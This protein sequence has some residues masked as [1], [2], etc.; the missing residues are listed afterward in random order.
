MGNKYKS[1]FLLGIKGVAMTNLA[2]I[3][4]K[5]GK[6]VTGYDIREEFI[7][8]EILKKNKIFW[9]TNLHE[10]PKSIDLFIYSAAHG[11]LKNK[12][13]QIA[14]R[15]KIKILSQPEAI[16]EIMAIFK[17]KIAVCGCHGK[18]TTSSLLAYSLI[19]LG[20]QPGYLVGTPF[21]N[22]IEGGEY[23]ERKKYFVVEAD[24][25]GINP[26][27]DKRIKFNFL[28]PDW[29]ICGN[30]D[31]DHPDVYKNLNEVKQA[32]YNFFDKRKLVL[33]I[34][35]NNLFEFYQK[36]RNRKSIITF[37][38]NSEANFQI[39]SYQSTANGTYFKLKKLGEFKISLFGIHNIFNTTSVIALLVHLGY[40]I[41]EIKKII[42]DFRGA[43][44]RFEVIYKK[45]FYIID[46]YA[47][48]PKEIKSVLETAKMI[49]KK[50]RILV[51][52]QPHTFSRTQALLEDFAK[53]LNLADKVLLLPIFA[54]ARE[55][56]K[57]YN[58]SSNDIALFNKDKFKYFE[59]SFDLIEF[60]KKEI[61]KGDV[62]FTLGAGD[63]YKIGEKLII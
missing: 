52:F 1:I 58:I 53:S 32:F 46:D 21:F 54:S 42:T 37:G 35:D 49:F 31:Y 29:I 56:P 17:N 38:K 48:H 3:F 55:N 19:K 34:D 13:A 18:T 12:L 15:K 14:K 27:L 43:K 61:R 4:K 28:H 23:N 51:V 60:M 41:N 16:N 26:P 10:L 24:E 50:H 25:Y 20:E 40:K 22:D 44:R 62:I 8:D 36:N 45:D 59:N 11:G 9:Q 7:T 33:N 57:D 47:H 5:M 6:N 39:E 2:V 30:I 63:V